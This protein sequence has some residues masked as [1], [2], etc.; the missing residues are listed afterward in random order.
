M[1]DNTVAYWLLLRFFKKNELYIPSTF[2]TIFSGE[3]FITKA[4]K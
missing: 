3:T 1:R 4:F 2:F